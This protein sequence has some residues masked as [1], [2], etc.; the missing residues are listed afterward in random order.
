MCHFYKLSFAKIVEPVVDRLNL[1]EIKYIISIPKFQ[2]LL[3]IYRL[4][5]IYLK[6]NCLIY[7]SR[8]PGADETMEESALYAKYGGDTG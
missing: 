3:P 8:N 2:L 6:V 1:I 4:V 5:L 7:V